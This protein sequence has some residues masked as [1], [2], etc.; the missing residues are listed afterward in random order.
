MPRE[1]ARLVKRYDQLMIITE[2]RDLM[3]GDPPFDTGSLE[4]I[5]GLIE[6]WP[7]GHARREFLARAKRL[8]PA[9]RE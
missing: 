9:L 3:P 2:W 8:L 5:P 7:W 4:P 6:P 1:V